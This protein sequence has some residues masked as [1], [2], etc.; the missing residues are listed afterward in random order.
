MVEMLMAAPGSVGGDDDPQQ[1]EPNHRAA[2]QVPLPVRRSSFL[3]RQ[4][5]HDERLGE[6]PGQL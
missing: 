2:A 5:N 6:V 4:T 1:A 3:R